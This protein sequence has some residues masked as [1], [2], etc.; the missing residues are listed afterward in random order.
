M[1]DAVVIAS[2]NRP[3]HIVECVRH[4][5]TVV[6][7]EFRVVVVDDGSTNAYAPS[8]ERF[9]DRVIC[10]R[11]TNQGP[12]AARNAGVRAANADFI[13]FT[14]DD[15]RPRQTWFRALKTAQG[16]DPERLVGGPVVNMVAGNAY[17]DANQ[18]LTAYLYEYFGQEHGLAFFT[19][20]NMGFDRARFEAIGGMD[21]YF[22]FASEDR[23]ISMRWR[24]GGGRLVYVPEAVV[25][26]LH[27]LSF[28]R[29]L[30]QHMSYGRGARR[31]HT[32]M[33]RSGDNP[34]KIEPFRFYRNLMLYSL[35][36]DG[37][38]GLPKS[39]L[40]ALSQV[41]MVAG[42]ALEARAMSVEQGATVEHPS[43]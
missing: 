17:S 40:M 25:D 33:T 26:H 19:T 16:D 35:R 8:L 18:D 42:Y 14:D 23:D 12:A 21:P 13:A 11:Q 22:N 37:V 32:K 43:Q 27:S 31:L 41:A 2:Y 30:R 10:I 3:D 1:T 39:V 5:L 4:L 15:C 20:N 36:R 28:R 6:E 24:A 29:F 38:S 7:G 34:P 9:G